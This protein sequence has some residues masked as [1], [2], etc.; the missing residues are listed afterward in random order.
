MD[1]LL[2]VRQNQRFVDIDTLDDAKV[3]RILQGQFDV[4]PL[5]DVQELDF[6]HRHFEVALVSW[7]RTAARLKTPGCLT[8]SIRH[9]NES[10][11]VS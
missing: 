10:L 2:T 6:V 3:R 9:N 8:F 1:I 11:E 4:F 5:E 7:N